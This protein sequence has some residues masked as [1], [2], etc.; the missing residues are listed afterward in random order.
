M[1]VPVHA[2]EIAAKYADQT[3]RGRQLAPEVFDALRDADVLRMWTAREYA[4][5][6]ATVVEVLQ[7]IE[8]VSRAD[9]SAG[10]C[11]MIAN[12]T[13]LTSH[14]LSADWARTIFEPPEAC[15]GG[16]GMPAGVARVVEGGIEVD[17]QWS[18]GSGTNHS[19]WIGGGV[20]VVDA[21]GEPGATPDGATTPFVFF[22]PSQVELLDTWHVAG[23]EGTGST[24]Y[25]VERAFVPEGRWVQLVG[26]TPK[27]DSPLARFPFF[28]ALATGICAVLIGLASRAIDE[29]QALADK[30]SMGSSKAISER[31]PIQADLARAMGLAGQARSHL[32]AM[33]HA[34]WVSAEQNAAVSDDAKADLRL[35][36]T[37][38]ARSALEAVDLCFHAVGGAAVYRKNV[39][40][41]VFRDAHIAATHGMIAPR[42]LEPIGR[43]AFGLPTSTAQF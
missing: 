17:G 13:A 12:T 2:L 26:G 31:A 7:A 29:V 15:T 40:Q 24:D 30:R 14:H 21:R 34:A 18:W 36:A 5:G 42:T 35:A 41:R 9:G 3:E 39:L 22:E 28:G 25:R 16:Y 1:Q 33:A 10:W 38:C 8:A 20:R 27:I 4:G 19:T 11:V 6:G 23:L 43:R 37:T 32:H